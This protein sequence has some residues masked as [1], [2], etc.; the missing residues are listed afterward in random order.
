VSGE[1]NG[2]DDFAEWYAA[3]YARV[4][5]AVTMAVG[6]AGVGEEAT[7]EAYARALMHWR[8]VQH[9]HRPE[10]WVYR[11]ALNYVRSRLRRAQLER[12]WLARQK[13][14]SHP[15]PP[16]PPTALWAAVAQLAP[17]ART[18]VALRYIADL[19]EAEVAEAMGISRGTVAAT[20][21]KARTRLG[22]L[23]AT[24]GLN[25]RTS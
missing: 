19:S 4:Q 20:L 15:P 5:R 22:E 6:D 18:A 9:A 23:L 24:H 12:R 16:E 17:R 2:R 13:M 21:S 8:T 14:G 7:A 10:A 1:A 11:T 25:E 3:S